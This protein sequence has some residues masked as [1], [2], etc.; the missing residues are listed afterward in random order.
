[1]QLGPVRGTEEPARDFLTHCVLNAG[2]EL[3]ELSACR[4]QHSQEVA[5]KTEQLAYLAIV[6]TIR[7]SDS[8]RV[9]SSPRGI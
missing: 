3:L 2:E 9:G 4:S 6:A 1:M 5:N 7:L 8:S